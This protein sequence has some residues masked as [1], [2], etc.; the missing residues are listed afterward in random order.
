MRIRKNIFTAPDI[1]GRGLLKDWKIPLVFP[2]SLKGEIV[3]CRIK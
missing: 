3:R 2:L 1:I